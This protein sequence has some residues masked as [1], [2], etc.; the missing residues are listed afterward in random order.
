VAFC[1]PYLARLSLERLGH[2]YALPI[3]DFIALPHKRALNFAFV[4]LI[5]HQ[6]TG[7]FFAS[8]FNARLGRSLHDDNQQIY[9]NRKSLSDK[10]TPIMVLVR[11]KLKTCPSSLI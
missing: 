11:L 10:V 7:S 8:G 3:P 4:D 6:S 2:S 5:F 9:A 1:T